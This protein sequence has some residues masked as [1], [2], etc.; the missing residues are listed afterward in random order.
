MNKTFIITSKEGIHARPATALVN[1]AQQFQSEV[2]V[3]SNG[4][5]VSLKS[6]LG[7]LSLGVGPGE[8]VS[9]QATG[10]DAPAV[11]SA[12]EAVFEQEGLGTVHE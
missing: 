9:F 11:M 12:I 6:I 1:V 7:V 10:E 3:G 2:T 8:Y 5:N 4:R